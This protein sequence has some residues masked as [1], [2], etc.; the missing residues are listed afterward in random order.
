M[1]RT[2]TPSDSPAI[3]AIWNAIIR[4][5]MATFTTTEKDPADIAQQIADGKP[6]WVAEVNNTVQGHATYDKFRNGPG[7]ARTKEHSIHLSKVAQRTGLGRDLMAA[8]ESHARTEGVHVMIAGVSSENADGQAFH[9][10]L[11]YTECGRVA[12]AGFKAGRYLDLVLM[13]KILT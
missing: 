6:W 13:Q 4:D 2:A 10:R 5:T 1:I 8:L 7:Y 11:G 12:Q 9:A 3:A